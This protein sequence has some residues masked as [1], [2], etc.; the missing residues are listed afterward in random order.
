MST[1]FS[2]LLIYDTHGQKPFLHLK[3]TIVKN[4]NLEE[5]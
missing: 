2:N 1:A 3:K 5:Q 4:E